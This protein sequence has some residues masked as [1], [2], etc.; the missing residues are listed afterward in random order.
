MT[1]LFKFVSGTLVAILVLAVIVT[2]LFFRG[3]SV[4]SDMV[5]VRVGAGP[6]EASKIKGDC[7]PSA[8]R[9]FFTNDDFKY[10]PTSEREWDATG[11]EG[12]DSGRFQSVTKDSVQMYIPVTVRFTL[13]T[14]CDT[15]QDF[16]IRY[17]RRYGVEFDN[18]GTYNDKW[19]TV[20]RKLVA[21]PSDATLDRI[22]QDYNWRN[23]WNDPQTKVDIEKRLNDALQADTSLLTTTAKGTFFDG[24]SVLVGKPEP[25]NEELAV[26]VAQEQTKVA[27]AQSEEAQAK[28]D[29]AK[30][31]AQQEVAKAEATKQQE[32]IEGYR[33]QGMTA[34]EAVR[35]YNE[36]QLIAKGGNP[37][38]PNYIVGGVPVK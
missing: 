36:A 17:A 29:E 10:F 32:T 33:L 4:P 6:F 27:Q 24:I 3:Y 5:A 9:G 35:A 11:Q 34:Q 22:I 15:L 20:L 19:L 30:A 8:T 13:I 25:V 26:A 16:Y 1:S 14:E 38:Q 18:D 21:D 28:A 7:V 37:Y 12:S 2:L 23:V 31:I